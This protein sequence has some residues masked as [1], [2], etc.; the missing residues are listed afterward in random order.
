MEF[1]PLWDLEL[2]LSGT[3]PLLCTGAVCLAGCAVS[4]PTGEA[5]ILGPESSWGP[6]FLLWSHPRRCPSLWAFSQ[7]SASGSPLYLDLQL[8]GRMKRPVTGPPSDFGFWSS[9]LIEIIICSRTVNCVDNFMSSLLS[10][11][12]EVS[13]PMPMSLLSE[14]CLGL[15][16]PSL[17]RA[18]GHKKPVVESKVEFSPTLYLSTIL[19]YF[20]FLE[21]FHFMLLYTCTLLNIRRK[22]CTFLLHFIYLTAVVTACFS[23][24]AFT[25]K[26]DKL[27]K[28]YYRSQPFWPLTKKQCLVVAP[29]QVYVC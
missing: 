16:E 22:H 13:S 5:E 18:Q 19:R 1:F 8:K 2:D 17:R 15:Q 11:L 14:S 28:Y 27:I 4:L 23:D 20:I 21:C 3:R 29:C 12:S 6:D 7:A 25:G 26:Q 9:F 24:L 10:G